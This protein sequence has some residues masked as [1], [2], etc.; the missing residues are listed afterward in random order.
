MQS[1]LSWL[2][3]RFSTVVREVNHANVVMRV[4]EECVRHSSPA[5]PDEMKERRRR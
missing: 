3:G 2:I 1:G 4:P 5:T